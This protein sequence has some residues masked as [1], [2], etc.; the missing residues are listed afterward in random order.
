MAFVRAFDFTRRGTSLKPVTI[1][2]L[3]PSGRWTFYF[4]FNLRATQSLVRTSAEDGAWI[5][6][7]FDA[8]ATPLVRAVRV[9]IS[10][11]ML[12]R[13]RVGGL[14]IPPGVLRCEGPHDPRRF[15]LSSETCRIIYEES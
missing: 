13:H 11:D 6:A 12:S 7:C 9:T 2:L 4:R 3:S 8:V 14:G 5:F 15:D 10:A 1:S